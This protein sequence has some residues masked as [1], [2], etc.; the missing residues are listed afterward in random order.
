MT[1]DEHLMTVGAEECV[2]VALACLALA[3]RIQ[4]AQ[5]FGM[6]QVQQD[7][8]DQPQQNPERLTNYERI[9]R[10]FVDLVAAMDMLGI[11]LS[12]VFDDEVQAKREKVE[13]YLQR[14]QACGTLSSA[15]AAS[16]A[17]PR[18]E[19]RRLR[20]EWRSAADGVKA[21]AEN[22]TIPELDRRQCFGVYQ[23]FDHVVADLDRLL[24]VEGA[25]PQK[26]EAGRERQG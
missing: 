19:L 5:R 1:R 24:A 8:D 16:D 10:E 14:S 2:E 20:D 22:I 18:A 4:K 9:R 13:R 17:I 25:Q 23:A 6:Q 21:N 3:Q 26:T 7:A 11:T 12:M 15:A